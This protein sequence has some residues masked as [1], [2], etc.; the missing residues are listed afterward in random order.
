MEKLKKIV[1]N[2]IFYITIIAITAAVFF[3]MIFVVMK[4]NVSALESR[5]KVLIDPGHG[6]ED[7]GAVSDSG[8][9]EKGVNLSIS[10][11]LRELLEASGCDVVMTRKDDAIP[12]EGAT[13]K[14]RLHD[15]F[16]KRLEMYNSAD[17]N[18]VVSI[19]QNKFT[20]PQYS[21]AQVFYSPNDPRSESLA[22]CIKRAFKGFLQ[23]E[24]E[25]EITKA[26]SNIYLLNNCEK[27]CVLVECGF[28][29][30]P[31]EAELLSQEEYQ[32]KVA[33]TIYCGIME[34]LR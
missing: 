28:L 24:N 25:R 33:F 2:V 26:G 16:T 7:G 12:G 10:L 22:L 32:R 27:P 29:S 30:N 5:P 31:E 14:E 15:D 6:A 4:L 19:H 20:Q 11:T 9:E 17:T 34:F 18:L 8:L 21:G 3:L 1:S 13:A 23:P